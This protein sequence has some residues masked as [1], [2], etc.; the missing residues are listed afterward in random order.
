MHQM[1]TM[2]GTLSFRQIVLIRMINEGFGGLNPELF[3]TNPS[4]CVEINR[5]QDYGL[6]MTDMA[7]FKDDAS[8]R[9]QI[10]LLKPTEYTKMVCDVL[11]LETISKEDIQRVLDSLAISEQGEPAEGISKE[12]FEASNY[13]TEYNEEEET[14]S[15]NHGRRK[16]IQDMAA[17][18]E[19]VALM[20]KGQNIMTD[21]KQNAS[22]G[23]MMSA[24]DCIMNALAIFKQ[25]KTEKIYQPSIDDALKELISY[26][27]QSDKEGG[28]RIL[29]GKR[30]HYVSILSDLRSDNTIACLDL[31]SKAEEKE[32]EYEQEVAKRAIDRIIDGNT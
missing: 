32:P 24:I 11:M 16:N 27:E 13:W 19:D 30:E 6:W 10:K 5:M 1:I 14:L 15:V 7:M 23:Y 4:A 2:A 31:L 21:A 3:I 26:F 22:G 29:V 12:D 9:I 28:L 20:I 17:A 25:C 18:P 8:A